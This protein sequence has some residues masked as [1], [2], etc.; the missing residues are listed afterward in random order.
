ML[1]LILDHCCNLLGIHI[2]AAMRK[3]PAFFENVGMV[4]IDNG[5]VRGLSRGDHSPVS[6]IEV[7]ADEDKVEKNRAQ[8]KQMEGILK[9]V[10][11]THSGNAIR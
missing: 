10:I 2:F 11:E 7:V 8:I 1:N 5:T 6:C 9:V 3:D 4:L